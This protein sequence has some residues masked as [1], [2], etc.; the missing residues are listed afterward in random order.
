MQT[1]KSQ[2]AYEQGRISDTGNSL[3]ALVE[4]AMYRY[5]REDLGLSEEIARKRAAAEITGEHATAICDWCEASGLSF[6]GKRVLEL[7]SGLGGVSVELVKRGAQLVSIEPGAAWRDL[8]ARRVRA[9]GQGDVIGAFGECIPLADNSVDLIISMQVLEHVQDPP[10]VI[11]EAWRVL[12]PGG[13]FYMTYENYLSF[14]EPHYRVRWLPLLPK[15]LGS[16]WLRFLGRNP[17]FLN[18]AVTYTTFPAVRRSF[19]AAGFE[20]MRIRKYAELLHSPSKTSLKWKALKAAASLSES[21]SVAALAAI[22]YLNR[23]FR[24]NVHEFMRKPDKL[25]RSA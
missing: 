11:H 20:C 23:M 18:E 15:P 3:D 13:S 19:F 25:R 24:T 2:S 1:R 12:K 6:R 22:D 9:V 5:L 16:A 7:G 14:W 10:R 21:G 17:A 8:A 4:S